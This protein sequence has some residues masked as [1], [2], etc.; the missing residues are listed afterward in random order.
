[1]GGLLGGGGKGYVGPP[2][3]IIGGGGPAPP[4]PPPLPTPMH[5]TVALVG[6]ATR[7]DITQKQRTIYLTVVYSARNGATW[8]NGN[9]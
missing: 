5:L 8:R 7:L 6:N 2:S 1:M 3:Q 9:L 4:L